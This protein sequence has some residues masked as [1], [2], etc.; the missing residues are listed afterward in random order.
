LPSGAIEALHR[1]GC[2]YTY[3]DPFVSFI[4]V[5]LIGIAVGLVFDRF[6]G[7]SWLTRHVTG[8]QRR[9][10]TS[11]LVGIAGAFI[12]Y[13]LFGLLGIMISGSLGLFIGAI[14]VA[15]G[16]LWAWREFA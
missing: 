6:M 12:G 15:V 9:M 13:H 4:I 5:L 11:S 2:M 1:E 3:T 14:I 8:S 10:I 7:Q 16:V